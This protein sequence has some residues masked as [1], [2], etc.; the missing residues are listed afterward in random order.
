[1]SSIDEMRE[2]LGL[3][4]DHISIAILGIGYPGERPR[5]KVLKPL[6]ELVFIDRYGIKLKN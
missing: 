6:E 3:P 2:I 4:S 5:E 1:L